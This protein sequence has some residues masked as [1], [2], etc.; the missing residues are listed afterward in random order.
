MVK[1]VVFEVRESASIRAPDANSFSLRVSSE[2]Q[3]IK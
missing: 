2:S 3:D 1:R